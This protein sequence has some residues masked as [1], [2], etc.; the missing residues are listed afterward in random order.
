MFKVYFCGDKICIDTDG[1]SIMLNAERF[2][3]L[4][5]KVKENK[6]FRE[7]LADEVIE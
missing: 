5:R 6:E 1:K 2:R 7:I 3:K 4:L